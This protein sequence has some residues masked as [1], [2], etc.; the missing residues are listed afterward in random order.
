[1]TVPNIEV[2]GV[3]NLRINMSY[4]NVLTFICSVIRFSF[5]ISDC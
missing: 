3:Q 1:M 2:Y 5:R 4:I